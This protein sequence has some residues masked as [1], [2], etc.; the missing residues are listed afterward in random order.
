MLLEQKLKFTITLD[1]LNYKKISN[2]TYLGKYFMTELDRENKNKLHNNSNKID[3]SNPMSLIFGGDIS[4]DQTIRDII[5][6]GAWRKKGK[7]ELVYSMLPEKSLGI[8]LNR[9]KSRIKIKLLEIWSAAKIT[10]GRPSNPFLEL[11]I[12]NEQNEDMK[13]KD[14]NERHVIKFNIDYQNSSNKFDYP[15]KKIAP[16][17]RKKDFVLINLETPLTKHNRAYGLFISDPE[18]GQALSRAGVNMVN[19]ANNHI[20]DAGEIGFE[21][22]LSYLKDT[23]ILF[24]GG[25]KDLQSARCGTMLKKN[26]KSMIF[27]G[28]TQFCNLKYVSVASDYAGILPLDRKIIIEDIHNAKKKAELV[29]VNLHWGIEN[30]KHIEAE[31]IEFAHTLID[32]GADG[33]I[34]HHPHRPQAIEI[35]KKKPIL[36][37]LG[38]FIFGRSD[39]RWKSDNILAE[40]IID[41]NNIKKVLIYP[42]SGKGQELFQPEILKG[43]RA[44]A[45][46][47]EI[48]KL[49]DRFG[50]KIDIIDDI[51]TIVI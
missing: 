35:Y 43:V 47:F 7:N 23:G 12:P 24:T 2:K 39:V 14:W 34:G 22:T 50:T 41:G 38:N 48:N 32:A 51:G 20:F 16:F 19:I 6:L 8:Y 13:Y 3:K 21:K 31:Q 27:L 10:K 44:E 36:Y 40:L 9:F 26:G 29:F 15:F 28:Y 45:L 1:I 4:F 37:S 42:I 17:L 5:Y 46:I 11:I 49:S 30:E 33:I 18:Y 25:G